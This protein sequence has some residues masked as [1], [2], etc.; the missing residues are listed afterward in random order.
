MRALAVKVHSI[1]HVCGT[2]NSLGSYT[3]LWTCFKCGHTSEPLKWHWVVTA[4]WDK[5]TLGQQSVGE[6]SERKNV[7]GQLTPSGVTCKNCRTVYPQALLEDVFVRM[8]TPEVMVP[9]PKCTTAMPM[10]R[11][12][13]ANGSKMQTTNSDSID[14]HFSAILGEV[15]PLDGDTLTL[16]ASRSPVTVAFNCTSCGAPFAVD[17]TNRTPPCQFCN[18]RIFLPDS[19]WEALHPPPPVAHFYL[20]LDELG[21]RQRKAMEHTRTMKRLG[22]TLVIAWV[23]LWGPIGGSVAGIVLDG[24]SQNAQEVYVKVLMAALFLVT[25]AFLI[26]VWIYGAVRNSALQSLSRL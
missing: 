15:E 3:P 7:F 23:L 20:W 11:T 13:F 22:Y 14:F 18:T 1:C 16:G 25:P 8:T 10:R 17:G 9:C 21:V 2:V 4:V 6:D 19:L 12:C 5:P 26:V 24:R